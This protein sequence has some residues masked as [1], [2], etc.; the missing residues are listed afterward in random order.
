MSAEALVHAERD[1]LVAMRDGVRLATDVFRPASGGA[2][3]VLLKRTPYGKKQS[4]LM[5]AQ[6]IADLVDRGY[7]VVVQDVRGRFNSEGD[8]TPFAC[9]IKDGV[10]TIIWAA[11]QP[12]STG[13]VGM[14]GSS[15]LGLSQL[16]AAAGCPPPLAAIAPAMSPSDLHRDWVWHGDGVL[17]L[18]L[19]VGW[20][21]V[22]IGDTARRSGLHDAGLAEIEL[23]FG[24][25]RAALGR[26]PDG[27]CMA[28]RR[29]FTALEP[30]L[31]RSAVDE[32]DVLDRLAPWLRV[33]LDHPQADAYWA[34]VAPA[35][36]YRHIATPALHI[37]GWYDPFVDGVI[38]NYVGLSQDA[39]TAE[40]RRGQRL[41]VG[42]WLH[43]GFEPC[44]PHCVGD[45]DF[46]AGADIDFP[47]LQRR[48]FDY[49]LKDLDNAV[50][51]EPPVR[52]FVMGDNCWRDEHEWPLARTKTLP[53]YLRG[54]GR[55]NTLHGDGHLG[56]QVPTDGEPPDRFG[57][58]PADPTPS[59]GGALL[60]G[61]A[62]AG[63]FDQRE[64]EHRSD[65]LVYTSEP[66]TRELEVTGSVRVELWV[67]SSSQQSDFTAQLVDV[68]PDGPALNLC[69]GIVR[70]HRSTPH[71][72]CALRIDLRATSNV[73]KPGHRIRIDVSSSSYPH[74]AP[75]PNTAVQTIY[76][77]RSHPSHVVLPVIPR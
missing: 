25:F 20:A 61:A 64:R 10:D 42:P 48:W 6:T 33:W 21:C 22:A 63:P 65:V 70:T 27:A 62:L 41:I 50:L 47:D 51:D 56:D 17:D 28:S 34:A 72:I 52:L 75:V 58:D 54:Q 39:A 67:S 59:R 11:A 3:P 15:Y 43:A 19:S 7:A 5:A 26:G 57:F 29:L 68:H 77:D 37:T 60:P 16:L 69:D 23:E 24:N 4:E 71:T 1:M 32:P 36:Y 30:F 18:L 31:E 13:R 14:F 9:E 40:A 53:L 35:S 2:C 44:P 46:G 8:W 73:F 76:H 74:Y 45:V 66:L 55:A 49:W 38:A 12:W